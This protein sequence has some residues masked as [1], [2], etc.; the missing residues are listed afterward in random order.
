MSVTTSSSA[1]QAAF[2]RDDALPN[3]GST[4]GGDS[5]GPLILDAAGNPGLGLDQDF[6]LGVLSGGSRFFGGQPR[7]SYGGT[8]FYQPLY[9]FWDYVAETNPYRYVGNVAGDGAWEDAAHW[10]SQLDPNYFIIDGNGNVVN[11][12]PDDPGEGLNGT[13]GGFGQVC[14]DS[15]FFGANTCQDVSNGEIVTT[16]GTPSQIV[17]NNAALVDVTAITG[18]ASLSVQESSIGESNFDFGAIEEAQTDALL[19]LPPATI[20]NGLPG[21]TGFVPDNIDPDQLN[22]VNGRYFDVTLAADGNTTLSSTVEIDRLTI[23]GPGTTLT[24]NNTGDLMSLIDITQI[25]GNVHV[26]GAIR[27]QGDYLLM[28]GMLSGSGTIET[29]FL[30]NVMGMISPGSMETIDTLTIDG[31]AVLAS[32]SGLVINIGEDG[33]NDVLNITGDSS[34]GGMVYF[35]P[36]GDLAEGNEYTFL[37]TGGVQTGELTAA[38]ISSII[39]AVLRHDANSVTASIDFNSYQTVIQSGSPNQSA[40][41]DRDHI[42]Q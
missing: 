27:S 6:I 32:A 4:A 35:I 5:G 41:A 38:P 13:G 30:T 42:N 24:V 19:V 37:T 21:A 18:G 28:S 14:F 36:M 23:N 16:D 20:E 3:E 11:G 31:S 9:L 34:L 26:D 22:G 29:P 17:D 2:L 33:N 7:S 40:Y 12:I 10:E 39:Q 8:S 1:A 25:A 15:V